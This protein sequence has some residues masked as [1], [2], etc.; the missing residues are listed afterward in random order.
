MPAGAKE[1][2]PARIGLYDYYGGSMPS[3]WTRWIMEQFHFDFAQVFPMEIDGGNL[4]EK[5]DVLLFI[6]PGMPGA[7]GGYGAGA[8]PKKEEIPATYHHMLGRLTVDK[9]IPQLKKFLEGGGQIITAGGATSLASQLGLPVSNAL[10]EIVNGREKA[11]T[12][13]KYYIPGS[14]LEMEVDTAA[15]INYGMGPKADIMFS[16]SPVFR[17]APEAASLGV[18]PLAWFGTTP[19]LRSG[20]AWGQNYLKQGVTAFEAQ[21]G[22]G[23]LVAFGPEIT[24]RGQAHGTFKLLFNGLYK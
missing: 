5:Y 22:K 14:V 13:D 23:K 8:Q 16:N 3:G 20:W 17:L 9:S 1:I 19:P 15:P 21:V 24:F 10:V 7:G 12:G 6:G 4:A 18:K 11:L 2:K